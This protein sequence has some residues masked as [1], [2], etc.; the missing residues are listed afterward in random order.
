MMIRRSSLDDCLERSQ[1]NLVQSCNL[2]LIIMTDRRDHASHPLI[3]SD[4][5]NP[6]WQ[7]CEPITIEHYWSG[8]PAIPDRHAEARI[9]WSDEALHVRFR[10]RAA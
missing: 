6:I 5:D 2:I 8:E 9:C 10:W 1:V 3:E 7:Q 4:F